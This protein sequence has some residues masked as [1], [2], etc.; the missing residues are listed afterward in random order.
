MY[1]YMGKNVCRHLNCATCFYN[2]VGDTIQIESEW[3]CFCI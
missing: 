1:L 3:W 2:K